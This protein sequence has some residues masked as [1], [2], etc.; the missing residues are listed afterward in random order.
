MET[1]STNMTGTLENHTMAVAR[2]TAADAVEDAAWTA[3]EAAAADL[4]W[5]AGEDIELATARAAA[6]DLVWEAAR[7]ASDAA[8]AAVQH[9]VRVQ[10]DKIAKCEVMT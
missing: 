6:A 8:W 1:K 9:Y 3:A 4:V 10:A 5:A 2:A 7:A